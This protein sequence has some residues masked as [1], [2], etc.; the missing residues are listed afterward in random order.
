MGK[1]F[2]KAIVFAMNA[3]AGQKRKDGGEYILHPMEVATI[4]STMTRDEDLLAA[5][6]LHD[7]VEDTN[8]TA[9]DIK[10][11][12]GDR[13]ASF[14]ASE[15]EDKRPEKDPSLTWKIRKE[16]NLE[17]LKN[18]NDIGVKILWLGDKLANMRAFARDYEV[19][20]TEVFQR[21]NQKDPVEQKWYY[22]SVLEYTKELSRFDAYKEYKSKV[23]KVFGGLD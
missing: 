20:G 22:E 2:D 16:E 19:I 4:V 9:Q 21:L 15:T 6:L 13:I 14:V 11:N 8:V 7:T 23:R 17:C 18:S 10:D 3:H 1:I 12:F 5:A